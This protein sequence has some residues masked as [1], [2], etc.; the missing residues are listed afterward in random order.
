MQREDIKTFLTPFICGIFIREIYIFYQCGGFSDDYPLSRS[1]FIIIISGLLL[2]ILWFDKLVVI[3]LSFS[4]NSESQSLSSNISRISETVPDRDSQLLNAALNPRHLQTNRF[5]VNE[6]L[7]I[8]QVEGQFLNAA[9]NP[10]HLQTNRFEVNERLNIPQV[11]NNL[12]SS[13][14]ANPQI[15]AQ[16]NSQMNQQLNSQQNPGVPDNNLIIDENS[17]LHAKI[18]EVTPNQKVTGTKVKVKS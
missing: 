5:E 3:S 13:L 10:R 18:P 17:N 14:Q 4:R 11:L 16:L 7:N 1:L 9:L 6:R 15:N 12:H 8:P 2:I